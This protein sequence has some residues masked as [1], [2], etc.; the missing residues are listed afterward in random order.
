MA[1]KIKWLF[2]LLVLAA[3]IVGFYHYGEQSLLYRV[4][5]LLLMAGIAIA[6]AAQTVSGKAAWDFIGT[7][8]TEVR[9]VVWP[10]RKETVQMTLTVIVMVI[11]MSLL[12]WG[13]D[14]LLGWIVRSLIGTGS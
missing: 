5:G 8:Q 11:I 12:L 4:G 3:G 2:A 1:D 10:S 14:S 6:L 7:S 13:F 9:K